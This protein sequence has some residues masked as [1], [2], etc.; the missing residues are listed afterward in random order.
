ML[1][2]IVLWTSS[3]TALAVSGNERFDAGAPRQ[4]SQLSKEAIGRV[5]REH[6]PEIRACYESVLDKDPDLPLG[7]IVARL[8]I[9][10]SGVVSNAEIAETTMDAPEIKTCVVRSVLKWRFPEF[11]GHEQVVTYPW[12]FRAADATPE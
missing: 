12:I 4:G 11:K 7:K 5:F 1:A 6:W 9:D 2:L 8:T 10:P 3:P